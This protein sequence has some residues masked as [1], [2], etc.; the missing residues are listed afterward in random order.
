MISYKKPWEAR[1]FSFLI[2]EKLPEPTFAVPQPAVHSPAADTMLTAY[3]LS[4]LKPSEPVLLFIPDA[5]R[6]A[7]HL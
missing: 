1:A 3:H 4:K 2:W 7:Q 5:Q 6:L